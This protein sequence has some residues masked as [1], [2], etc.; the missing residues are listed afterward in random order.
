MHY[1]QRAILKRIVMCL[2]KTDSYNV[3]Q[4]RYDQLIPNKD[5]LLGLRPLLDFFLRP[6]LAGDLLDI[7]SAR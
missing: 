1:V 7:L 4:Q 2:G 5:I 6:R 3:T